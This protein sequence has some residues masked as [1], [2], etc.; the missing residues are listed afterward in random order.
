MKM[1]RIISIVLLGCMAAGLL[2]GCS[3]ENTAKE[4]KEEIDSKNGMGKYQE[5]E[6]AVPLKENETILQLCKDP[7]ET[8]VLYAENRKEEKFYKYQSKDGREWKGEDASWLAA[9]PKGLIGSIAVGQDGN[10][11]AIVISEESK[12][13]PKMHLLKKTAPGKAEEINIPDLNKEDGVFENFTTEL[14]VLENGNLVLSGDEEIRVYDAAGGKY[15]Y[16][17]QQG[18]KNA[19]AACKLIGVNGNKMVIPDQEHKGF[20]VK[21]GEKE[22]TSM[23]YGSEILGGKVILDKENDVYFLDTS[24]IHH[25]QPN[26]SLVETL[27]DSS[28]MMMGMPEVKI[29]DFVKGSGDDFYALYHKT[30][31]QMIVKHYFYDEQ[32]EI[33]NERKLT[34][35]SLK[36][37]ETVRWAIAELNREHQDVEV[38][39]RT[40]E[41]DSA[42]TRADQIRVLNTELMNKNGADVLILD[43]LP[44]ESFIEKGILQDIS[45]ILKPLMEDGTLQQNIAECYQNEAGKIYCM[46]VKYGVPILYGAQDRTDA[47]QTMDTLEQWLEEH[48]DTPFMEYVSYEAFTKLLVNMYYEELFGTDGKL[49][50]EALKQCLTIVKKAEVQIKESIEEVPGWTESAET[51]VREELEP[52]WWETGA[53]IGLF[54]GEEVLAVRE[55]T[56]KSS[57]QGPYAAM[58]EQSLVP[59]FSNDKFVPHIIA[60][61]NS[62]TKVQELAEDFIKNL[63]SENVQTQ[64]FEDGLPM[65]VKAAEKIIDTGAEKTETQAE[66][67]ETMNEPGTMFAFDPSKNE[68]KYLFESAGKLKKP[69]EAD[70]LLLDMIFEEA[71]LY[72]EGSKGLEEAVR[73]IKSKVDTY[74]AE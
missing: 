14:S 3:S 39:Y 22:E 53:D 25:M 4:E 69:A 68:I 16:S 56:G 45:G 73:G 72:Y 19:A 11:Y 65:N 10:E 47:M 62:E 13:E 60:G 6:V 12:K 67:Q 34:I 27:V 5:E 26:G 18:K 31:D 32:A 50:E 54:K 35:Y 7:E 64:D 20:V 59:V 61:I 52:C 71:K 8:L 2:T 9:V 48:P 66:I 17:F 46:P 70:S 37:N 30:D 43:D 58:R 63:Y 74:R 42:A 15:L 57:M 1:K 33:G 55:I 41:S 51:G 23:S 44:I 21:D 28:S 38:V 49:K 29:Q 40:G 36:E 24:G